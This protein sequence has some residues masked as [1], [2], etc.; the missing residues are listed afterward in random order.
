MDRV[1]V[2][3]KVAPSTLVRKAAGFV[4]WLAIG[5]M[6]SCIVASFCDDRFHAW[7]KSPQVSVPSTPGWVC[8]IMGPTQE[9]WRERFQTASDRETTNCNALAPHVN[10][11][12]VVREAGWPALAFAGWYSFDD[13]ESRLVTLRCGNVIPNHSTLALEQIDWW[14][15]AGLPPWILLKPLWPGALVDTILFAAAGLTVFCSSRAS[16]RAFSGSDRRRRGLCPSCGYDIREL[17][18]CPE[19]GSPIGSANLSP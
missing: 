1:V 17:P 7:L 18:M 16:L 9:Q 8:A 3:V 19:C 6:V 5:L 10:R 11:Y 4:L 12:V 2:F 14:H 13:D 15:D